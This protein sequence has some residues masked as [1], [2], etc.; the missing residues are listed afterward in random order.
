MK[1]RKTYTAA[2]LNSAERLMQILST[3]PEDKRTIVV[4]MANSFVAGMEAREH[5][6]KA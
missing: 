2:E 6:K 5:M 1:D 4:M 3:I